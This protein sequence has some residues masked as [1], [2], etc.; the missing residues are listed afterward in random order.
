MEILAIRVVAFAPKHA[1]TIALNAKAWKATRPMLTKN[2]LTVNYMGAD[3][4]FASDLHSTIRA[5]DR[6][7]STY[8][9]P[10]H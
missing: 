3:Q 9:G 6:L 5:H 10:S 4:A 1:A 2:L 8:N 7:K